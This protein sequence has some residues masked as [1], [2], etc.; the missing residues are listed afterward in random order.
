MHK[1][2][3][4]SLGPWEGSCWFLGLVPAWQTGSRL[5]LRGART[6]SQCCVSWDEGLKA[7]LWGHRWACFLLLVS[8][9]GRGCL[10]TIAEQVWSCD[11]GFL[12]D[13]QSDQIW[14]ACLQRHG[15]MCPCQ[16]L[17]RDHL[18]LDCDWGEN[19]NQ[20]VGIGLFEDLWW[21]RSLQ[22][23]SVD[24]DMTSSG[25]LVGQSCSQTAAV[26]GGKL[27]DCFSIHSWNWGRRAGHSR[28]EWAWLLLGPLAKV[29]VVELRPRG[30]VVQCAGIQTIT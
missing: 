11:K 30:P 4:P 25:S 13:L 17:V 19:W 3:W 5:W 9:A 10:W 2:I 14:L 1:L 23:A 6:E 7:C 24:I 29:L 22:A 12:L 26:I 28:P 27:Q 21:D 20:L 18:F 8:W 16:S 15:Y